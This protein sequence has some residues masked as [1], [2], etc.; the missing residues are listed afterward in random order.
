MVYAVFWCFLQRDLGTVTCKPN[1]PPS[2]SSVS[3]FIPGRAYRTPAECLAVLK[4]WQR[5]WHVPL[6]GGRLLSGWEG[7]QLTDWYQCIPQPEGRFEP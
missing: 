6:Q 5:K 3:G 2:Y 1:D 7:K 4:R